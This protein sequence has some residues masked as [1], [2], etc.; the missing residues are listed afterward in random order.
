MTREA[1]NKEVFLYCKN[2]TDIMEEWHNSSDE[3]I[4]DD[5]AWQILKDRVPKYAMFFDT[6]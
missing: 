6:A 5:S 4:F 2:E 1:Q 3:T